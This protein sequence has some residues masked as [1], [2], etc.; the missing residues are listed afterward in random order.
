MPL[1]S[2]ISLNKPVFEEDGERTLLETLDHEHV[3]DPEALFIGKE[4]MNRIEGKI[5]EVLSPF[6]LEVLYKY[7]QGISYQEIA[8]ILNKDVK[9]IDNALQRIKKKV[10]K[11]LSERK[12]KN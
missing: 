1:N 6:E 2:Y 10:E 4:E 9:A 7:L 8:K 5:N 3:S 12:Y 11:F